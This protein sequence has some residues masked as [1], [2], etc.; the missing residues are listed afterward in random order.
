M[1]QISN[2]FRPSPKSKEKH[3]AIY[4]V[5]RQIMMEKYHHQKRISYTVLLDRGAELA[6]RFKLVY[7]ERK[8]LYVK[9]SPK[10]IKNMDK[11]F[12]EKYQYTLSWWIQLMDG[13]YQKAEIENVYQFWL[14]IH[15]KIKKISS[16]HDQSKE[17]VKL[18]GGLNPGQ[19][20]QCDYY[21]IIKTFQ[22]YQ[23]DVIY[24]EENLGKY[25]AGESRSNRQVFKFVIKKKPW[26]LKMYYS[27]NVMCVIGNLKPYY[28]LNVKEG[29]E[30][31][32]DNFYSYH[33]F[34]EDTPNVCPE[35]F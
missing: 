35:C 11:S 29:L 33:T 12:M 4:Q 27:D 13:L 26:I 8:N 16:I 19:L 17:Y 32:A 24:V 21:R 7:L 14:N 34:D 6:D 25:C 30:Y 10:S 1:D 3:N 31:E 2:R 18:T 23:F 20:L 15:D 5:N 9:A 28:I 22:D